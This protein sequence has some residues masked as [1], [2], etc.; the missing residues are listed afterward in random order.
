[1]PD[2]VNSAKAQPIV[3]AGLEACHQSIQRSSL[4]CTKLLTIV[5]LWCTKPLHD[6]PG[7]FKV[8]IRLCT[9]HY[10]VHHCQCNQV[11]VS[12]LFGDRSAIMPV[13]TSVSCGSEPP[14]QSSSNSLDRWLTN[15][16]TLCTITV[17]V[18]PWWESGT[19]VQAAENAVRLN[20]GH[21][22]PHMPH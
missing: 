2:Q 5:Q 18:Q 3:P 1:M 10:T 16:L 15:L 7:A 11:R 14:W 21:V 9:V 12:D 17:A 19:V 4:I 20:S 8:F 6:L 13:E 22:W